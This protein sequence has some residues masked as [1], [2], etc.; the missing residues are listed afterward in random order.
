MRNTQQTKSLPPET[1]TMS[2]LLVNYTRWK[3][4]KKG[5]HGPGRTIIQEQ[6][7]LLF[8][9]DEPQPEDQQY[10]G[11]AI[12][13]YQTP[14][15]KFPYTE[16]A[17][18]DHP[19][20]LIY[21]HSVRLIPEWFKGAIFVPVPYDKLNKR[22]ASDG[23]HIS[24]L[25]LYKKREYPAK[26]Y[27]RVYYKTRRD[28]YGHFTKKIRAEETVAQDADNEESSPEEQTNTDTD[29][30][31]DE[32]NR[33]SKRLKV[34]PSEEVAVEIPPAEIPSPI[35]IPPIT[36]SVSSSWKLV[37]IQESKHVRLKTRMNDKI[38][39]FEICFEKMEEIEKSFAETDLSI[40]RESLFSIEDLSNETF[41]SPDLDGY[42]D[43]TD[44][45]QSMTEY[46][47]SPVNLQEKFALL[48]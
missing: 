12:Y 29:D 43:F 7:R 38:V 42:M 5:G 41:T 47:L 21:E 13:K 9:R 34:S 24:D 22:N 18:E 35:E 3:Y 8:E 4:S 37:P 25:Y 16:D 40:S 1:T 17:P 6:R 20:I 45:S 31:D 11:M 15:M 30:S 46:S 36:Q 27:P 14:K 26:I 23:C 33:T 44:M 48:E 28:E 10:E 32:D 2:I 39:S 19:D